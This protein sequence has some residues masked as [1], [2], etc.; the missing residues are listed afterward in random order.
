ML[1]LDG[2]GNVGRIVRTLPNGQIVM[3]WQDGRR[4]F[5]DSLHGF[6]IYEG[7]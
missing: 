6:E 1:Y 7:E 4:T 2:E 5:E 3:E